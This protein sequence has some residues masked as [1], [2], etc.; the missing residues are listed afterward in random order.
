M[1]IAL[2]YNRARFEVDLWACTACGKRLGLCSGE[3]I[4][5][6]GKKPKHD[7]SRCISCYC[8]TELCSEQAIEVKNSPG[9]PDAQSIG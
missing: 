3:A 4:T 1:R 5:I 2:S 9:A 6:E 7:C 8:C